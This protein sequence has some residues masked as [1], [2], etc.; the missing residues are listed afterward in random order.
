M[1]TFVFW[2]HLIKART[3]TLLAA[4]DKTQEQ[5]STCLSHSSLPFTIPQPPIVIPYIR[6]LHQP[7]RKRIQEDSDKEDDKAEQ[8]A[9]KLSRM[10][11]GD[12][13]QPRH[14]LTILLLPHNQTNIKRI[15]QNLQHP[16]TH[17]AQP[18]QNA[19][20]KLVSTPEFPEPTPHPPR[21]QTNIPIIPTTK[22]ITSSSPT[23]STQYTILPFT[24]PLLKR[25][26]APRRDVPVSHRKL[27][28]LKRFSWGVANTEW[29]SSR[30]GSGGWD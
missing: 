7:K 23:Q 13:G 4:P 24:Y 25:G 19:L 18:S 11:A 8:P 2:D 15:L 27:R 22:A 17:L 29:S 6:V 14:Q 5:L 10:S 16:A 1:L 20:P 9:P 3:L 28:D 21:T 26:I 30:R 12:A